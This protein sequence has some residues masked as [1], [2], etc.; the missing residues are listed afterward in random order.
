M[1]CKINGV[2]Y[3]MQ[4]DD[5]EISEQLG[6]IITSNVTVLVEDQPFPKSGDVI[7]I[8]EDD[9]TPLW[10]G[11]CGIPA[12][13]VYSSLLQPKIYS[14]ECQNGNG[15]LSRRIVNIAMQGATITQIVQRL[16]DEYISQEGFTLGQISD[17][18][19]TF[20]V[21]TA[22]DYNLRDAL[23]ELANTVQAAWQV[24][25]DR[26]FYF[27]V[28]EDFPAFP[29]PISAAYLLGGE[30]QH[31][32]KDYLTRTVQIVSGATD[33]TDP[34]TEMLVYQTD[35][36]S[37]TTVFPIA[38]KPSISVN[39][40]P[41]DPAKIGV[42]G[43]DDGNDSIVF[44][45]SYDSQTVSYKTD[46]EFLSPGDQVAITYVGMY[47]IRVSARN[48]TRIAE[49]AAKTGTSG[50]IEQV[51]LAN[52]VTKTS[53][54]AQLA[55]SLLQRFAE[56]RGEIGFWALT[57]ELEMLG[58]SVSDFSVGTK[59]AFDLPEIGIEGEYVLSERTI[60]VV[61]AADGEEAYQLTLKLVDRDSLKSY[62]Q[63]IGDLRKDVSQLSIRPEDVVIDT[64]TFIETEADSETVLWGMSIIYFATIDA[65]ENGSLF[66]PLD[67]GGSV[68]PS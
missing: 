60:S 17:I 56:A 49:I 24:T 53:D 2:E 45:F 40:A 48:E 55:N 54:A 50:I 15:I 51:Q 12:S 14:I 26:K 44:S 7:E 68:Y 43:I 28:L 47:K 18:P 59:F 42:N 4:A 31:E 20:E 58:L 32:T 67:L 5:F 9:D 36:K 1:K 46:S 35:Q 39:S 13:P 29:T 16:F 27:T 65:V 30:L 52:N 66:A 33:T 63:I 3:K 34:Q 19:V 23:D 21:Y 64:R 38:E 22:A 11:S 57:P 6:N 61:S 25:P 62:G 10:L 8:T 37:F 41:V